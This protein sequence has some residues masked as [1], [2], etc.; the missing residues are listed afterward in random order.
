MYGVRYLF[1]YVCMYVVRSLCISSAR[2]FVR[3][4]CRY[5]FMYVVM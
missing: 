2:S 1:I 5:L 3:P 4:L